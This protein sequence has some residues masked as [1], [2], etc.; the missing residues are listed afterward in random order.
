MAKIIPFKAVRPTRDKVHLV[1]SR[2]F[3]SYKKNILSAKLESNPY[4]FIHIINPE[5]REDDRTKPNSTE[6][7]KKVRDKYQEFKKE[8]VLIQDESP[9]FYIYRQR[10]PENSFTG[11]V[12]GA[13][14]QDYLDKTIKVHEQTITAREQV[15]KKY[16]DVCGF[17]AEPVLLTYPDSKIIDEVF[18]KYYSERPEFEFATTDQVVHEIWP[19]VNKEDQNVISNEFE[20]FNSIYIADGHHRSSSSVLLGQDKTENEGEGLHNYFLSYIIPESQ[21][22]IYD[23]NRLALDLN[24][25]SK[26]EFIS[27]IEENFTVSKVE[28]SKPSKL[29]EFRMYLEK[30]WYKLEVKSSAFDSNSPVG[31]LDSSILSENILA[32]ILNVT[33]LKTSDRIAFVGGLEGMDALEQKVDEGKAKVAFALFPVSVE[34]LKHVADTGS[35][36]PPKSTWIEPKLRSGLTIYEFKA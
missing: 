21:L 31:N 15:F 26:E 14:I 22:K 13:S 12:A 25:L 28:K 2:A 5:F 33:D 6:R 8:G 10:G 17:N 30:E 4:S 27:K 18:E 19:I 16:L 23:F 7:F 36:M 9:A 1:A 35:I 20:S 32:P 34:Q 3:Y 29:H 24:G 11:I